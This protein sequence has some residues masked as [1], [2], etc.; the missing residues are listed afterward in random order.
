MELNKL[1]IVAYSLITGG[2]LLIIIGVIMT[3]F[4]F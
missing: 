1:E 2:C 3:I 4:G